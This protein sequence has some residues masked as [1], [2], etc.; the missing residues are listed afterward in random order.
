NTLPKDADANGAYHIA[1]KGL[2]LLNR[3]K[4]NEVEEFEKSKKVKDGKSQ[5]LPNKDWLDFVQ[6]NVEDMVVV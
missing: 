2:V 1:K 3:L 5:W 6:R 4:E